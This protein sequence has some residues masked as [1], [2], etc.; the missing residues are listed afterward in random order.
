M[1]AGEAPAPADNGVAGAE[2][3][4]LPDWPPHSAEDDKL[5]PK[6]AE[7]KR[8]EAR[9]AAFVPPDGNWLIDGEG[10][11]YFVRLRSKKLP[12]T[13]L[14]ETSIRIVY[15]GSYDLAGEDEENF[16]L[17]IYRPIEQAPVARPRVSEPPTPEQL[18]A[19]AATFEAPLVDADRLHFRRF[20]SGLPTSGLWRNGFDLVDINGD[21]EV[22]FVH[23]P[24]RRSGDQPRVFTGD[25]KGTWRPFRAAVPPG[26]LDYGDIKVADFNG[27]GKPDLAAASHLR[28]ISVFVGDGA[29]KFVPWSKGLD[30]VV[31]RAG[32][33]GGGFSSRRIEVLD[34]NG[35]GR[36]DLVA[37][38][39]GPRISLTPGGTVS[40]VS[41]NQMNG[42]AFGPKVYINNGDGS[43]RTLVESGARTEI[44]G[45]DLAVADFDGD[46][47]VDFLI[48]TNVMSRKDLLYVQGGEPGDPWRSVEV[49]VRP[50][51]YVNAIAS[52]DF[53]SDGRMDLAL[54][55]TSFELGVVRAGVDL[56]LGQ[57]DGRWQRRPVMVRDGRVALG[58]LDAGDI[59]GDGHLDLAATDHDGGMTILLGDGKGGF[60]REVSP[61]TQQPRS[62]CRGYG[63]RI[64]DLDRDGRSE[65]V[66]SYAGE[67]NPLYDPNRCAGRGGVAAWTLDSPK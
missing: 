49:P 61:E 9:A 31:P 5:D 59:D 47:R 63:L 3:E 50:K 42:A 13:R 54:T 11:S 64:F 26:L 52:G 33:D 32:Y 15:G 12:F 20:D 23:A 27:D 46:K 1:A 24:P 18:A 21:G 58:A 65:I 34:W 62:N 6:V 56:Y 25:G 36:P 45:D 37:L 30:F 55:Y 4:S 53:D 40:K 67:A 7:Q 2:Q 16:W 19:S 66:A 28:G 17:K 51:A 39:E 38:S 57:R 8:L 60:V 41:G 10:R 29:G 14:S 43:W 22:D 48:S 44:F 35:D